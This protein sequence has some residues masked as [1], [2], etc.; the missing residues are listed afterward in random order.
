MILKLNDA[1]LSSKLNIIVLKKLKG[2]QMSV[3]AIF[4][5]VHYRIRIRFKVLQVIQQ[6]FLKDS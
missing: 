6:D 1:S 2:D 4:G 5:K 3:D